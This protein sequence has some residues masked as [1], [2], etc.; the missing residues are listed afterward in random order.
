M[1]LHVPAPWHACVRVLPCVAATISATAI[2]PSH[3][4]TLAIS[5]ADVNITHFSHQI[6][7]IFPDTDTNTS[8]NASPFGAID[9]AAEADATFVTAPKPIAQNTTLSGASGFGFGYTGSADSFAIV[10]GYNFNIKAGE[11]FS[12]NFNAFLGL[13]TGIDDAR[14]EQA[15]ASGK[16]VFKLFDNSKPG[17]L[18]PLDFLSIFGQVNTTGP[19]RLAL[20]NSAGFRLNPN[21]TSLLRDFGGTE[22][23]AIATVQ[24]RFSRLF[25]QNTSLVLVEYKQS[26]VAVA[27]R[28]Q[29]CGAD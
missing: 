11:R 12:F 16:V 23:T 18:Q 10:R 25:S 29:S 24:G 14:Y 2:A 19:D 15:Q 3:A 27:A 8:T 20:N 4:A 28:P 22:E 6:R 5:S 7:D 17:K 13:E 21:K 1:K 9:V 26:Q